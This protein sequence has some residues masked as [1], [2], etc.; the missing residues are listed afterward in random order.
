M[1]NEKQNLETAQNQP[2]NITDVSGSAFLVCNDCGK[3]D[4]TVRH[5]ESGYGIQCYECYKADMIADEE[6]R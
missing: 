6:C 1:S 2:L 5:R 4:S 3:S